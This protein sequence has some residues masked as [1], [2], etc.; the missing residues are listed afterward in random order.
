MVGVHGSTN[1]KTLKFKFEHFEIL[2]T[3]NS[4]DRANNLNISNSEHR[5]ILKIGNKPKYQS[6]RLNLVDPESTASFTTYLARTIQKSVL[7]I[8][9]ASF[10][11]SSTSLGSIVVG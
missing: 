10:F 5:D 2:T 11:T 6:V 3:P 1:M 7:E 8:F 9:L 4:S